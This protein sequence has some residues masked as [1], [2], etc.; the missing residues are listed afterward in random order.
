MIVWC[1]RCVDVRWVGRIGVAVSSARVEKGLSKER[2]SRSSRLD[3]EAQS[4]I[5]E[6]RSLHN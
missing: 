5:P 6:E 1:L 4:R 3:L 2:A